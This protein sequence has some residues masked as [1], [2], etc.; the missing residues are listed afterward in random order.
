[1]TP[2]ACAHPDATVPRTFEVEP[3]STTP[4]ADEAMSEAARS[5]P[6]ASSI[7][8][9]L[10]D[11]VGPRLAGSQADKAAV[12]WALRTMRD[13]GLASVHP[14]PVVVPHWER[15]AESGA[16]ISPF[17][18]RL[19]LTALGGSIGTPGLEAE[20][21]EVDSLL[22]LERR[23]KT[24]I[25]GKIVFIPTK[26]RP[27]R[28]GSDYGRAVM[29][30][31]NGAAAAAK[32]GAV[33][34]LVE[35][36]GSDHT[37]LPHTGSMHP[38]EIPAA[39]LAVPDAELLHRILATGKTVRLQVSLGAHALPDAESANVI[40]EVRGG[41]LSNEL[42]LLAAHLDSWDLGTGALDDGAGCAIVL[43]AARLLASVGRQP[44]RTVRVTLFANEE[45]GLSGSHAYAK[46]HGD[47]VE[48]HVLGIEADMGAGSVYR[49]RV[50]GGPGAR[51]TFMA[52]V[53]HLRP[54][55][56]TPSFDD[57]HGGADLG[58][59][60]SL[61]MPVL[62][63]SQDATSYFD[64]HHSAN[65][66]LDKVD[67]SALEQAALAFALAAWAAADDNATFGRIPDP[68]RVPN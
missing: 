59:L 67:P 34:Y 51:P 42:V 57:A 38:A 21:V 49:A 54:L 17:S 39:A 36:V 68:K 47:E 31:S 64:H 29:N 19:A 27:L 32:L 37:R 43:E 25:A 24:E 40:G 33:G 60:R 62:D 28:D 9:S 55:G 65:D 66:T 26:V 45:H 41:D 52:L 3:R 23:R 4:L 13:L 15:G 63:L 11:E 44:R 20:V 5:S 14:E 53:N 7:L 18:Q 46:A 50:L 61:G 12:A 56:I 58:D 22:A 16:I 30:R 8:R 48:R 1:M 2:L 35:S 10:T 6:H